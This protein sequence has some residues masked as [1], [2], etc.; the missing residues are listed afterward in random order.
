MIKFYL[1]LALNVFLFTLLVGYYF[2]YPKSSTIKTSPSNYSI[3]HSQYAAFD[4]LTSVI[5]N[6]QSKYYK[7]IS[8]EQIV[9]YAI[10]GIV[11]NLDRY[12]EIIDNVSYE[13]N[14]GDLEIIKSLNDPNNHSNNNPDI[15]NSNI[16]KPNYLNKNVSIITSN[17]LVKNPTN[18]NYNNYEI[19]IIDNSV[20]YLKIKSFTENCY[21]ET[22]NLLN[23][24][25]KNVSSLI[26]DLQNNSG[27]FVD[28][29]I[30]FTGLFLHKSP[31][32][33]IV[34]NKGLSKKTFI[35]SPDD[36]LAGKP[37]IVLINGNTASAAEIVTSAL[38]DNKRALVF[39]TISYGKGYIQTLIPISN[40]EKTAIKLTTGYYITPAGNNI[41]G[42]GITPDIIVD[43][44]K[45]KITNPRLK[46]KKLI[47]PFSIK[48]YKHDI[49]YLSTNNNPT[50][51]SANDSL[52]FALQ[53]LKLIG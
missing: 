30:L 38:Q 9:S 35:A 37:I 24:K 4:T 36:I 47:E 15:I 1:S 42:I 16:F 51:E 46:N 28:Q 53:Y 7:D 23:S 43:N 22:Y 10:F 21:E 26:I 25:L 39:G 41:Q 8:T 6:V 17:A 19:K 11:T 34:S 14:K 48:K 3:N 50:K 49:K 29:A 32:V 27:G 2:F 45:I 52:N 40:L 33:K 20:G 18:I 12:S 5:N 31:V 44:N 13:N